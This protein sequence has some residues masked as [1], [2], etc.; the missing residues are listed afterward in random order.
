MCPWK[1]KFLARNNIEKTANMRSLSVTKFL[2][3]CLVLGGLLFF[4]LGWWTAEICRK[5]GK[6]N[7]PKHPVKTIPKYTKNKIYLPKY[8]KNPWEKRKKNKKL[9][10]KDYEKPARKARI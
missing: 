5:K 9:N 10:K 3:I 8:Y 7:K 4:F 1:R 6:K 2:F